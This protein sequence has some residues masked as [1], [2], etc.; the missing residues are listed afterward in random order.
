MVHAARAAILA[1]NK[2][3]KVFLK[4]VSALP[5]CV[6]CGAVAMPTPLSAQSIPSFRGVVFIDC[7]P[8]SSVASAG[9]VSRMLV[10]VFTYVILLQPVPL[11]VSRLV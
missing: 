1:S 6:W 8:N 2:K 3:A 4:A 10:Y 11:V 7:H 9:I 5:P